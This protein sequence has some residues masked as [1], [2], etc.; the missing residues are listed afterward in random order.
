[1]HGKR[2]DASCVGHENHWNDILATISW[3]RG[4][5]YGLPWSLRSPEPDIGDP[6]YQLRDFLH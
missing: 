3:P 5:S 2:A 4:C 1:M 6:A